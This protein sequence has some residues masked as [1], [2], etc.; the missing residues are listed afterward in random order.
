MEGIKNSIWGPSFWTTSHYIT[1]CYPIRPKEE[2]KE[3]V[4][5]YFNLLQHLLPCPYCREH[6]KQNL[7]LSPLTDE[8]LS[9]KLKLVI[10]FINMHNYINKQLGKN[11]ISIE[12]A[13][14]SL[15]TPSSQK[16]NIEKQQNNTCHKQT[17][18]MDRFKHTINNLIDVLPENYIF[19]I[20]TVIQEKKEY[21]ENE[22]ILQT[23]PPPPKDVSLEKIKNGEKN[24]Q[25]FNEYISDITKKIKTGVKK[26]YVKV[27]ITEQ[28]TIDMNIIMTKMLDLIE[29]QQ[30]DVSKHL[31]FSGIESICLILI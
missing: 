8:I 14:V 13:L 18:T 2:D 26:E 11:E 22:K 23:K 12:D 24:K 10:W 16:Q 6:Y 15:F 3:N 28:K 5:T 27:D 1:L 4:R 21:I 31:I 9:I 7:I 19:D 25:A 17:Y 29:K 30:D 20:D